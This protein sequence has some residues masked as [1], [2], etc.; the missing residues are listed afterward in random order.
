MVRSLFSPSWYRVAG[1]KPRLRRHA[2]IHRHHYRGELWYVLQDL[3]S[4]RYYRFT[5]NAYQVIGLMDGRLTVQDLWE[6]AQSAS[7]TRPPPRGR[8]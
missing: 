1:L 5:P 4:G 2:Q 7:A 6:K 8:W 3:A